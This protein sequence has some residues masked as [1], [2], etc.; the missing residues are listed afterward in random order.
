MLYYKNYSKLNLYYNKINRNTNLQLF[1]K[2]EIT[3]GL[4]SVLEVATLIM[5]IN[6]QK[7]GESPDCLLGVVP[8]PTNSRLS[9]TSAKP[10]CSR[11]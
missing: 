1:V 4:A 8:Q 6:I 9:G 10:A 11:V 5:R 7:M 3:T 2:I